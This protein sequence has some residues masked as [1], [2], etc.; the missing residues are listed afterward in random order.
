MA[1]DPL[2]AADFK[3]ASCSPITTERFYIQPT[4]GRRVAYVGQQARKLPP[5]SCA[6]IYLYLLMKPHRPINHLFDRHTLNIE[7]AQRIETI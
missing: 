4:I 6:V 5:A 2:N 3:C 7:R 1:I